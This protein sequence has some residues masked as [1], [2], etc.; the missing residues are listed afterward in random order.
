MIQF[1]GG[2]GG[3]RRHSSSSVGG[4]DG[5]E[6]GVSDVPGLVRHVQA[7]GRIHSPSQ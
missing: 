6:F 1:S 7:T 2:D 5:W 4:R 3:A